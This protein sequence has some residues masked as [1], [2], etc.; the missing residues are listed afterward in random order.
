MALKSIGNNLVY[1]HGKIVCLDN[2]K[3]EDYLAKFFKEGQEI[4]ILDHKTLVNLNND[5]IM[6]Y[7]ACA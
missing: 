4:N 2:T 1:N 5:A 3:L 7:T 6:A